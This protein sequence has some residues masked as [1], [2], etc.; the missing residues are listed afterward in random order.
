M[1]IRLT[2][3]RIAYILV[4][5]LTSTKNSGKRVKAVRARDPERTRQHL[6][7][8]AF[9]E[10][11]RSGYQSAD[12]DAILGRAGVTKGALYHHF[13][14]KEA[15]GYAVIEEVITAVTREKWLRPLESARNPIDALIGIFATAP[16]TME[17]IR[18]GC[19]LNNLAQEMSSLHEGFRKRIAKGF[20]IW[21]DA[22]ANGLRAGQKTKQVRHNIDPEETAT[23]IMAVY[24]G[25]VSLSKNL[26]DPKLM[27]SGH[28]SLIEYLESLRDTRT[29]K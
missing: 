23:F 27:E 11:Y 14:N 28:N 21:H 24:E 7:Q 26:H 19:P 15:L 13:E 16:L 6:L 22:I 18:G 3:F 17:D 1:R 29:G 25:Y 2:A 5:M 4:G 20:G 12:L 8:A 9:Q 10:I